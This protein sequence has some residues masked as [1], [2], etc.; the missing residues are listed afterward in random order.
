MTQWRDARAYIELAFSIQKYIPNYVD[1]YFGPPE[2][3]E[4]A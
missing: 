3:K 1:A 4:F 2:I